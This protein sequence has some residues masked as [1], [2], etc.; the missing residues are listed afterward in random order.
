MLPLKL[1]PSP[2]LE[3]AFHTPFPTAPP[4][5]NACCPDSSSPDVPE[6]V[7]SL[8]AMRRRYLLLGSDGIWE[9]ITSQGACETVHQ[10]MSRSNEGADKAVRTLIEKASVAWKINEGDYRDDITGIVVVLPLFDMSTTSQPS[11]PAKS[12]VVGTKF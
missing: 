7:L 3:H 5:A 8:D 12:V 2:R 4:L 9:F 11:F 6:L 1:P 10:V